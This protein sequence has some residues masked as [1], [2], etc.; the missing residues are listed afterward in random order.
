MSHG[1]QGRGALGCCK[2]QY[3]KSGQVNSF[4]GTFYG[5]GTMRG[6]GESEVCFLASDTHG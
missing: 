6:L 4:T 3:K 2:M 1:G 5:P